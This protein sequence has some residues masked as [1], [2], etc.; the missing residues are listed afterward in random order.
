MNRETI[1]NIFEKNYQKA[2]KLKYVWKPYS[3]A[4]YH[5]WEE[6]DKKEEKRKVIENG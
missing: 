4:L 5:T 3:W 6:V 2:L 1:K